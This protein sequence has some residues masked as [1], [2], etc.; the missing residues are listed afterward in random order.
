[1]MMMMMMM[2]VMMMM[3]MT[4]FYNKLE[5]NWERIK[6]GLRKGQKRVR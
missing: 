1:M 4:P 5:G 3:M 6:R 2:M